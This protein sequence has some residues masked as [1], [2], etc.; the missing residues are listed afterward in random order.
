M[1]EEA[2]KANH[3]LSNLGRIAFLEG[4]IA[5]ITEYAIWRDG[6]QTVG[7]MNT[8][9]KQAIAPYLLEIA[10]IQAEAL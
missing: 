10:Q 8:P 2:K 6:M 3:E 5:G 9:L 4:K 7:C 1:F